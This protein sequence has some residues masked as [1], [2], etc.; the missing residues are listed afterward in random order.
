MC[1]RDDGR[2]GACGALLCQLYFIGGFPTAWHGRIIVAPL[3]T[4]TDPANNTMTGLAKKHLK[5]HKDNS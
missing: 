2:R 5:E 1:M 3:D 4:F